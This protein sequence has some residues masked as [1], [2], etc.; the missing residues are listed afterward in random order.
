MAATDAVTI[1]CCLK[2]VFDAVIVVGYFNFNA[3]Y[4]RKESKSTQNTAI[5]ERSLDERKFILYEN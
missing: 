4:T 3:L 5:P 2:N 1:C